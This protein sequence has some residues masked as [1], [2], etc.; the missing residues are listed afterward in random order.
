MADS[1]WVGKPP[2]YFT[3]HPGQLELSLL[4]SMGRKMST[5]QSVVMLCSWG[6][7]AGMFIPLVDKRVDG[8]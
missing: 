3:S 6:V 4:S 1:L 2:Q 8:R 5:I 7:K